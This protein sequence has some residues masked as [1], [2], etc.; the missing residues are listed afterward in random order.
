MFKL[1]A[2]R[3]PAKQ[4]VTL[5]APAGGVDNS[6]WDRAQRLVR[7][8]DYICGLPELAQS[9]VQIDRFCLIAAAYFNES[10]LARYIKTKEQRGAFGLNEANG[11]ELLDLSAKVVEETLADAVERAKI[12]KINRIIVESGSR[13]A[14]MMEAMI[15]SD[16]R[17]L[18]DMGVA[19]VLNEFRRFVCCGRCICDVVQSW[20]KKK[21]YRY[22]QARLKEGFRFEP[23]RRL[24]EQRLF[25]AE[26]FMKQLEVEAEAQDLKALSA[27]P[28]FS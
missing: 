15:L 7:T 20:R 26:Q 3:E 24:A 25:A 6:L 4:A 9:S 2:I 19:G 28:S 1:D 23:V 21:D 16:A 14:G 27:K 13:S 18:E 17:N 22:W 5:Q 8:V 12:E 11:E 10:G